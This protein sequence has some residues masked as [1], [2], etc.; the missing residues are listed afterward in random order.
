MPGMPEEIGATL[1]TGALIAARRHYDAGVEAD[2]HRQE[3][4]CARR[5]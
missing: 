2:R 5:N 4:M 1:C 3:G